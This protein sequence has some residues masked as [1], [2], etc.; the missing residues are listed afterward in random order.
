MTHFPDEYQQLNGYEKRFDR[1]VQEIKN[2]V[3]S[4]SRMHNEKFLSEKD[5]IFH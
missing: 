2:F 1:T 5:A 4:L 3:P